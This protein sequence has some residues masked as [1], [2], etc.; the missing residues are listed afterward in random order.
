MD[1]EVVGSLRNGKA[2]ILYQPHRF[3][4]ELGAELPSSHSHSPVPS[5]TFISVF[6]KPAAGQGHH[7]PASRLSLNRMGAMRGT[8]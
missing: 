5:N 6:M 4:F 7:Q 1:V 2:P 8:L 3:K